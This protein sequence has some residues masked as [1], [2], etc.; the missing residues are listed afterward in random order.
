[1]RQEVHPVPYFREE[2]VRSITE[3]LHQLGLS[4]CPVCNGEE[5]LGIAKMPALVHIG[6]HHSQSDPPPADPSVNML[7]L[8][9]IE[10]S[11]CGYTMF[12]NSERFSR[13]DEPI[14]KLAE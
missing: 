12:F 6:D 8:V 7:F 14:L 1:M 10:C 11:M 9:M 4:R 13:K 5:T 3:R 2:E